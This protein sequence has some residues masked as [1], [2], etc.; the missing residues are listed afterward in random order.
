[1]KTT[2]TPKTTADI[3]ADRVATTIA[4]FKQEFENA[5]GRF[6]A[7][8]K[9]CPSWAFQCY[10][11]SVVYHEEAFKRL[12]HLRAHLGQ[13]GEGLAYATRREAVQAV[14]DLFREELVRAATSS[15]SSS[16][17]QNGVDFARRRGIGHAVSAIERLVNHEFI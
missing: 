3:F 10:G 8:A 15:K 11:E 1:V 4:E 12:D 9:N 14:L 13:V 6:L 16:D 17:F 5:K 2:K 7:A